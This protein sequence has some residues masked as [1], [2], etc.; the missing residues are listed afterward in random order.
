MKRQTVVIRNESDLKRALSWLRS[1]FD[2]RVMQAGKAVNLTLADYQAPRT[3][4]QN[5][6]QHLWYGE[7]AEQT[8]HTA[9]EIKDHLKDVLLPKVEKVVMGRRRL[10]PKP[11]SELSK[12]EAIDYM[13]R[14]QAY[15]IE[16]GIVLTQP[17]PDHWRRW[18]EEAA[19]EQRQ[20]RA[21]A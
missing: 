2:A 18:R 15:A 20:L 14:I 17:D 10:V 6:T 11:T 8:G 4:R 16:W 21:A 1:T 9:E 7:F 12:S 5:S 3:S 19:K 13:E